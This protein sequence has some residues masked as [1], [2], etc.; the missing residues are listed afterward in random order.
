MV[1][2]LFLCRRL[3]L[4]EEPSSLDPRP[5][6]IGATGSPCP[7]HC[8]KGNK[9]LR[10]LSRFS[11]ICLSW[12]ESLSRIGVLGPCVICSTCC[13]QLAAAG[14]GTNPD[15]AENQYSL[16]REQAPT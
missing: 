12:G 9:M 6:G 14:L 7:G 1:A 8:R 15:L 4:S 13:P 10:D 3:P 11:W 5:L 16:L 2:L